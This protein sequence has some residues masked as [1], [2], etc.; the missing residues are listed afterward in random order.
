MISD[1]DFEPG[2]R[3]DVLKGAGAGH[4]LHIG[5]RRLEEDAIGYGANRTYYA[6]DEATWTRTWI[7]HERL[8]RDCVIVL[9]PEPAHR[10]SPPA[11][12]RRL[13]SMPLSLVL[14]SEVLDTSLPRRYKRCWS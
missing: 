9:L 3:F 1:Q 8:E 6:M 4:I 11:R 14:A 12:Q 10:P 2:T 7:A 13:L 5:L